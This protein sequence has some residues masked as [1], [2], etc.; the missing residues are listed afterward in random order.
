MRRNETGFWMR[1]WMES[2]LLWGLY[3]GVLFFEWGPD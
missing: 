3:V 1:T 2:G